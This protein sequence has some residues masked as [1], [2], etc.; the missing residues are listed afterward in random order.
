M[1]LASLSHNLARVRDDHS[2]IPNS[3]R[4][5]IISLQDGTHDNHVVLFGHLCENI[6]VTIY[7]T[8]HLCTILESGEEGGREFRGEEGGREFRK[9]TTK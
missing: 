9:W 5:H 8:L 3:A 6:T 7:Y 2:C 4:V 1:I